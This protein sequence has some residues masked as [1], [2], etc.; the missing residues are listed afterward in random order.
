MLDVN[1]LLEKGASCRDVAAGETVFDEG[2]PASFYYQLISGRIRWANLL[3]N[4]KEVLHRMIEPGESFGELPLFD[5]EPYAASAI[6]DIPTKVIRLRVESFHELLEERPDIHRSFTKL[7]V[8]R[9]RFSFFLSNTLSATSP[10]FI[11]ET[12]ID[13]FNHKGTYI[14]KKCNRLLLTRQQLANITGLRVETVI[15]TIKQM[16][17]KHKLEVVKGKVFIPADGLSHPEESH[18]SAAFL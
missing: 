5:G 13:Y 7:F 14:C 16:E 4:G 9:L 3:D 12:L 15:R 10:G 18:D 8:E 17:R 11:L 6:A 2:A 1:I